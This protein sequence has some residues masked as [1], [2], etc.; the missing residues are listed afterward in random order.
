[1]ARWKSVLLLV[2][3]LITSF[4]SIVYEVVWGRELS[5]IF[6]TSAFAITTVLTAFMAGLALGSYIFG[7][8]WRCSLG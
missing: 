8:K 7:K 5:F 3:L 2:V 4:S 1:M 6:G